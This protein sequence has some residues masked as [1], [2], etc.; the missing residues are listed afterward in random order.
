MKK[1]SS[2]L[3]WLF[4][5]L[6]IQ[7]QDSFNPIVED[8]LV[9]E[10]KSG[11][12]VVEAEH[13]YKQTNDNV[14]KWYRHSKTENPV[15]GRDDD[16]SH[17]YGA[18]NNSYLEILPDSRVTH[19][20]DLITGENF[21]NEQGKMAFIH[22][23][24]YFN[25]PGRYY[26][27]VRAFSTG[28][29]DNGVHVGLNGKW[30]ESGARLQWC[31]G[32]HTW[33]WESRQRTESVHC[34]EPYKIYIDIDK[35]GEHEIVFSMREDG[36]EFDKFIMTT[37]KEY[38]PN[39]DAIQGINIKSGKLPKPFPEVKMVSPNYNDVIPELK[40]HIV[41]YIEASDYYLENTNFYLD[42]EKWLAINPDKA[43]EATISFIN[44]NNNGVFDLTIL[45][46][47]E[48]DG[49]SKY[50]LL[51]NDKQIKEY[52]APLS[53]K[54]FEE[55]AAYCYTFENVNLKNGDKISVKAEI[56]SADGKEYSRARWS[57]L[58]IAKK[59]SQF[60]RKMSN[61]MPKASLPKPIENV[62]PEIT[63]EL[64]KWHKVTLTFDG[65]QCSEN[66]G[67][68]PFFNY[69]L[70]VT[71]TNENTNKKYM[72]PGYF[73][74]DGNAGNTSASSG[75]KWRVHF[76]PD[77]IGKWNYSVDFKKGKWV[78]VRKRFKKVPT[79]GYMDGTKGSFEIVPSDKKGRDFRAHG[80]LKFVEKGYL[81][82][83]ETGE[84][85]YKCGPDAPENFLSY[86]AFDGDF[87]SDGIKDDLVKTWSAHLIDWEK[88]DP[89][90]K[91][92]KGKEMIGALNYI[93]SKGLNSV[94][95]ITNNVEGDDRNVFPYIDYKTYDRFDCSKL[96]QWEVVF[97][98]A[99][100]QGIFLHFKTLEAENQGLFDNGGIG[101]YTK[102]YFRELIARFGHHL[103]LNWNLCEEVGDWWEFDQQNSIPLYGQ[104][105]I[106]LAQYIYEIDPYHH[107]MVIHNGDWYTPMYGN[108]S[109][110]TGASLQTWMEDF[111]A[112]NTQVKKVIK[113]AKDAGKVWAVACDEPGDHAHSLIT[114][115]EDP[116][117]FKA[118]TNGLWGA[119]LAGA[120]GTE[121]Y[122]GYEHPHSD[123]SCQDYRSRDLF[124]NMGAICIDFFKTNNLPVDDMSSKNE[125]V[126]TEGDYCFAKEGDTYL[127]LLKKGGETKLDL[128]DYKGKYSI[129]W[130]NPRK[131]GDLI[132]GSKK[133]IEGSGMV[134]IGTPPE[135]LNSDWVVLVRIIN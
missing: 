122:F 121:W 47:G 17:C 45:G 60:L 44:K 68:N 80:R 43:K 83:S 32:K 99:Q 73:A 59:S 9:F 125:L 78:A 46:V 75:N 93:A 108:R 4:V 77:E 98:H 96:D 29:E 6:T 94:S 84:Y 105:R 14:R 103:A 8:N 35:A 129:N 134:S 63:G 19:S 64:Q 97:S 31:D 81:K 132:L 127:L 102:L 66:D 92:N 130:F 118:R 55:N 57:G 39:N 116:E 24:T 51:I 135:N 120:W 11:L 36:F 67:Y 42:Q 101:G 27:W 87:A 115:K 107:H 90:W 49:G 85:F 22:Y 25:N 79:G 126:S 113:E 16:H 88:G 74:A 104:E 40:P 53:T 54:M 110:L 123:L 1:I 72:V 56:G 128:K 70:N 89:T 61:L 3:T 109:K 62:I 7:A 58:V 100:K 38:S 131:G 82:F 114:D 52:K 15:V 50:A 117:H 37:D 133:E 30:P 71:F 12:L 28:S 119:M 91:D 69:R 33:R 26:V 112:V 111:S 65:P 13:F 106:A 2:L 41:R 20:D 76:T 86:Y 95:F 124:W 48:N 5:I 23:K 10:E 34:G 21:S 18:S